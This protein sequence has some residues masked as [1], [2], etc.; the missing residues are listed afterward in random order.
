MLESKESEAKLHVENIARLEHYELLFWISLSYHLLLAQAPEKHDLICKPVRRTHIH[1][2]SFS[3][4]EIFGHKHS[5]SSHPNTPP[6]LTLFTSWELIPSWS[7]VGNDWRQER[8]QI[9]NICKI[10]PQQKELQYSI[11]TLPLCQGISSKCVTLAIM[12]LG[13]LPEPNREF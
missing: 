5:P 8:Y 10:S 13:T 12:C 11:L 9:N 3:S 4:N 1:I 7:E 6:A 2:F